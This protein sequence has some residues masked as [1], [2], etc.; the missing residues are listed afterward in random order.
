M[1]QRYPQAE[2]G[3][4]DE[5]AEAWV[6]QL[7]GIVDACRALRGEMGVS[8]AQKLPLVAVGERSRLESFAPCLRALSKLSAVEIAADLPEGSVAPVQIV[9]DTRLMLKVE[10]DVAAERERLGKE[11]ARI[12]GE[13]RKAEGK[14]AN[15]SFVDRAPA[16]V[17]AQERERLAGFG[18]TLARL[19]EQLQRLN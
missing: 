6:A 14:L 16:P 15:P 10:V 18:G 12:E 2:P 11:I 7:K 1:T 4:I 9:G 8:P 19:R 13:V 5:A 3:R 17:V